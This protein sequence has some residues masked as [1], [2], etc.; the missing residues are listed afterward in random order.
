MDSNQFNGSE[1]SS[2]TQPVNPYVVH[3]EA[4]S[5]NPY[6]QIQEVSVNNPYAENNQYAGNNPYAVNNPY[7]N[8]N[9][10][11]VNNPYANNNQLS[12]NNPYTYT[13][14]WM[15]N[16]S[17]GYYVPASGTTPVPVSSDGMGLAIAGMVCGI[18]SDVFCCT[19]IFA[20]V[21]AIVGLILS[22]AALVRNSKGKGMAV[23]GVVC[24]AVGIVLFVLFTIFAYLDI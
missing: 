16:N 20:L 3:Q 11:T 5:Q 24:S 7:T 13:S 12:V 8:N 15:N 4:L 9:Q 10:Q 1:T 19:W 21:I 23:A 14:G 2:Y 22:I 6:A 18:V 17:T